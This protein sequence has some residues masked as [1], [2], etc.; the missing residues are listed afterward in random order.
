M[1]ATISNLYLQKSVCC[2]RSGSSTLCL[3]EEGRLLQ[4]LLWLYQGI[5]NMNRNGN[6]ANCFSYVCNGKKIGAVCLY[7]KWNTY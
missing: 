6:S 3:R 5:I 1:G 7:F 2:E 4:L